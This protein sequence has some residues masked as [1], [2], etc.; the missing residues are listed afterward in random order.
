MGKD[1]DQ[2]P[3]HCPAADLGILAEAEVL[4]ALTDVL[5]PQTTVAGQVSPVGRVGTSLE[6]AKYS[7]DLSITVS[8][9]GFVGYYQ[10]SVHSDQPRSPT[11]KHLGNELQDL[12]VVPE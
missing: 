9:S 7:S 10:G 4:K 5:R 12:V 11:R 3:G 8:A 2:L 1:L 6:P